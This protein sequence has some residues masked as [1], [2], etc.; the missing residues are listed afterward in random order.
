MRRAVLV[1]AAFALVDCSI[2]EDDVG[3]GFAQRDSLTPVTFTTADVRLI[4][5]RKRP[6]S[7][8]T[9]T[10]TEPSPDVAKA[11]SAAAQL[12]GSGGNGGATGSLAAGGASAEAVIALAG[13]STALLG[14]RD[15]L[16][17]ACEAYANGV[18]GADAY[19]LVLSR[20][21]QLMTTLFLGQDVTGA[22]GTL[23]GAAAQ[24][25]QVTVNLANAPSVAAGGQG[26]AAPPP[27]LQPSAENASTGPI[28][29]TRMNEDYLNLGFAVDSLIV[30]CINYSD[31]TRV[32]TPVQPPTGLGNRW[33]ETICPQ[34]LSTA[35]FSRLAKAASALVKD[36]VL[37]PPVNPA[38]TVPQ[39]PQTR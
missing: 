26:T 14:L 35:A 5:Q 4:T 1:L 18:I 29:L 12:S 21:G 25:P 11:L 9:V 36:G 24:S 20:Y 3:R 39:S 30:A 28:A 6:N 13:R 38:P 22:A 15:G 34:I 37:A 27:Q 8:D 23:A 7:P 32:A 33:L 19:A 10:C 16:Y 2:L 31:P 17:R